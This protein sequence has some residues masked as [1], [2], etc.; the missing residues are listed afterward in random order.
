MQQKRKG[1]KGG[2]EG[3]VGLHHLGG[4][5]Q[6]KEKDRPKKFNKTHKRRTSGR[7]IEINRT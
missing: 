3:E 1:D 2:G 4:T 7:E 6:K 5:Y